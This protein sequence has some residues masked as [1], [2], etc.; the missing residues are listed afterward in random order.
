MQM[1]TKFGK[2]LTY[3]EGFP[4]IKLHNL[5]SRVLERLRDRVKILYLPYQSTYSH[6]IWQG[7]NLLCWSPTNKVTQNFDQ[8]VFRN[9]VTNKLHYISTTT[10]P[11]ANNLGRIVTKLEGQKSQVALFLCSWEII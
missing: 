11:I 4:P 2:V 10:V 9:Q 6:Q 7:S 8:L 5:W 1:T 3:H